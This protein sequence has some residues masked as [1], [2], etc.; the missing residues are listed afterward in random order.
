[1][2]DSLGYNN[3]TLSQNKTKE[4]TKKQETAMLTQSSI[5]F[6]LD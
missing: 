5:C 2:E 3:E 1:M 6:I 4:M